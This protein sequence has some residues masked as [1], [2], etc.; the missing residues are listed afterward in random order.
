MFID[1]IDRNVDGIL[2]YIVL[3]QL[4]YNKS[5]RR[6]YVS[7]NKSAQDTLNLELKIPLQNYSG[8]FIPTIT[9]SA[10]FPERPLIKAS[11]DTQ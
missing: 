7:K 5:D 9:V 6:A 1:P 4:Y 10:I 2:E 8:E 11:S 3:E